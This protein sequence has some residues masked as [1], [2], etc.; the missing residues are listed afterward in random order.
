MNRQAM[1]A[2]N[3]ENSGHHP[4]LAVATVLP[5]WWTWF[6]GY[7]LPRVTYVAGCWERIAVPGPVLV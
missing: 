3:G 1:T 4:Q 2:L 5:A 7:A 6:T